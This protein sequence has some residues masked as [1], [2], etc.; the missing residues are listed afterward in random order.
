[1]L[2]CWVTQGYYQ[3]S[4]RLYHSCWHKNHIFL[5]QRYE[6]NVSGGGNSIPASWKTIQRRE[7]F[8]IPSGSSLLSSSFADRDLDLQKERNS[9]CFQPL[10]VCRWSLNL[11]GPLTHADIFTYWHYI[12][13]LWRVLCFLLSN[14]LSPPFAN[15]NFNLH[16]EILHL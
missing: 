16:K 10:K 4:F 5:T 6:Q 14:C 2:M 11:L 8:F 12:W 3:Y 15:V 9:L 13:M 7:M 1:M